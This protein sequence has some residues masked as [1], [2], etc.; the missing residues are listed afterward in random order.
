MGPNVVVPHSPSRTWPSVDEAVRTF[1][2]Q[3]CLATSLE[4]IVIGCGLFWYHIQGG[5]AAKRKEIRMIQGDVHF[6]LDMEVK[7]SGSM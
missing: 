6:S 5:Y 2:R 4:S 1:H 3:A 7:E